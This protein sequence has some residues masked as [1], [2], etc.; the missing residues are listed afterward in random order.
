MP[1]AKYADRKTLKSAQISR[2]IGNNLDNTYCFMCGY[3]DSSLTQGMCAK[4]SEWHISGRSFNTVATIG[5]TALNAED[6]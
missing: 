1:Q 4:C 6:M 2:A 3:W 5:R